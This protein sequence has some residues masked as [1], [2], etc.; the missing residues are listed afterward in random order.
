M[1]QR[2]ALVLA[3]ATCAAAQDSTQ[4]MVNTSVVVYGVV[5]DGGKLNAA[6]RAG[7]FI[8][9]SHHIITS[10]LRCCGKTDNGAQMSPFVHLADSDFRAKLAYSG[11]GDIAILELD[12]DLKATGV[13]YAPLKLAEK[14]QAVYSV[15]IPEKG[16]PSVSEGQI[17]ESYTPDK[18]PVKVYRLKAPEY[19]PG[20]AVFDGCG[21]VVGMNLF[22]DKDNG[23]QLALAFDSMVDGMQKAGV[24]GSVA[25]S[26]CGGGG[27]HS[28]APSGGS[29]GGG[30][31]GGKGGGKSGKGGLPMP[32]GTQ[33]IGVGIVAA[34]IILALRPAARQQVARVLTTRR[35]SI[36]DPPPYG[37]APVP[38]PPA[39]VRPVLRGVS[40]QYAG[41]SIPL[42]GLSILGRDQ[43]VANLVFA[44]DA[45]SIS[46]QHCSVRWDAARSVFVIED[47][48]STNGT[49][50][51]SGEKLAARQARDLRPGEKF[52]IGDLRNQFEVALE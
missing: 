48:G 11:Q 19:D 37:A 51:A 30:S 21:N 46:K 34:L 14:G 16:E 41:A 4:H 23:T 15:R 32:Q 26:A 25:S 2:I 52:Y 43:H 50:L 29:G 6:A 1:N 3:A 49:F 40:G 44:A 31:G 7:G 28:A 13:S 20:S 47:L 5:E 8:A 38:K 33:W 36:P 22:F 24:E 39:A 27:G 12:R 42:E 35:S 9:D 45:T 18:I 10:L 17:I